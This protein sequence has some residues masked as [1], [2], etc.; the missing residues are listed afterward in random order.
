MSAFRTVGIAYKDIDDTTDIDTCDSRGIYEVEKTGL[1]L[2]A[3]LGMKDLVRQ[4]VPEN[5]NECRKAGI[6]VRMVTGDN[7]TTARVCAEECNII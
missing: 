3:I 6:K 2:I 1:T 7:R 4:G 5:I